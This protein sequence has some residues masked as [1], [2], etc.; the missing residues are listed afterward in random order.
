VV[1]DLSRM[2]GMRIDAAQRTVRAQAGL[3]W[4]EFDRETQAYELAVTGGAISTT[5]I[6][7]LTL[8]GGQGWLMRKYGLASDNLLSVDIVT[9]EGQVL[10]ANANE[11]ADLF[12]GLR[13]GSGNFGIV[14]SFEYRLY[15]ES[16][17]LA[18]MLLYPLDRASD[19]MRFWRDFTSTAPEELTSAAVL[20]TSP[21][22]MPVL[23]LLIYYAGQLEDG[24]R[25]LR[26]LREFGPPLADQLGPMPY[27]D[28]QT[29]LDA[30]FPP[31][32]RNYWKSNYLTALTD[33]AIHAIA[34]HFK[35]VPSPLSSVMLER[36]TRWDTS[37][38]P[39]RR[40]RGR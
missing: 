9:A 10:V 16:V 35:T 5:G 14:T 7:G 11:H 2:K 8:G 24:E 33:E 38:S 28:V 13:G 27:T 37:T 12:W 29:M 30:A 19:V 4:G 39:R 3:T 6:A 31:G 25:L 15:P 22:G 18:G 23:A 21:D 26:P 34:T 1:I 36:R 17:L 40:A 32:V 20:L